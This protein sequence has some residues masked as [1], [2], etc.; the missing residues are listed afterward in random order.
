MINQSWEKTNSNEKKNPHK[1]N[2]LLGEGEGKFYA[3]FPVWFSWLSPVKS[4]L[5]VI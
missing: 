2:L 1:S 4:H 5:Y 3:Q